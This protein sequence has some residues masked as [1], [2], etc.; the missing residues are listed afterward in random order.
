MLRTVELSKIEILYI[1]KGNQMLEALLHDW[2][3]TKGHYST[4][5][6]KYKEHLMF[7]FLISGQRWVVIEASS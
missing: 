3:I 7:L 4:G 6:V 1:K 2:I 5:N